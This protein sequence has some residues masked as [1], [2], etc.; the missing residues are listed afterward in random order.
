[1]H[2]NLQY[3]LYRYYHCIYHSSQ[4]LQYTC[5][6]GLMDDSWFNIWCIQDCCKSHNEECSS[7]MSVH[8]LMDDKSHYKFYIS[9]LHESYS[10]EHQI[11]KEYWNWKDAIR[12]NIWYRSDLDALSM[13]EYLN[14]SVYCHLIYD[15]RLSM[16]RIRNLCVN[17]NLECSKYRSFWFHQHDNRLHMFCSHSLSISNSYQ[18]LQYKKVH[19]LQDDIIHHSLDIWHQGMNL[20]YILKYLGSRSFQFKLMDDIPDCINHIDHFPKADMGVDMDNSQN[21]SLHNLLYILC[22]H[23]R[24]V[25]NNMEFLVCIPC[26]NLLNHTHCRR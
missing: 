14:S 21:H 13:K 1:M 7:N 15:N 19:H 25:N 23:Q 3:N 10:I 16:Y 4:C 9:L 11:Y 12:C 17:H 22:T 20:L 6:L 8:Q 26:L 2:D 5:P 24:P 18:Y